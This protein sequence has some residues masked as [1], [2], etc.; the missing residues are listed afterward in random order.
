MTDS[1]E[2]LQYPEGLPKRLVDLL[3]RLDTTQLRAVSTYVD[4]R[5]AHPHAPTA[6][7]L[8]NDSNG[9][10]VD[11]DVRDAYTLVWKQPSTT[12]AETPDTSLYTVRKEPTPTGESTLRWTYIGDVREP[13]KIGCP[14]C[15]T[16][17]ET[18]TATCPECGHD[19]D[20]TSDAGGAP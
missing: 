13:G 2:P 3:D 18:L 19:I 11:V 5:L 7:E 6:N 10:I 16:S 4:E 15:G 20:G 8:N 14:N 9:T 17:L 1:N 12:D